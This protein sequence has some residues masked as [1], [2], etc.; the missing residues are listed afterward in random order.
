[1]SWL[2]SAI[3]AVSGLWGAHQ[4]SSAQAAA[5]RGQ[6]AWQER[7]S[8]TAHQREVADLRA[9]G[10]NPILSATG[11]NGASTPSGS[12]GAYTGQGSDL[13]A[14]INAGTAYNQ[15]RAQE[16]LMQDQ[17][18]N[19]QADTRKKVAEAKTQETVSLYIGQ[20]MLADIANTLG[21]TANLRSQV[22]Y[23]DNVLTANTQADTRLKENTIDLQNSQVLLNN[24][25]RGRIIFMTNA[26]VNK[27]YAEIRNIDA[28]TNKKLSETQLNYV[29]MVTEQVYQGNLDSQT[30]LNRLTSQGIPYDVA[31]KR[32]NSATAQADLRQR[33]DYNRYYGTT[34]TDMYGKVARLLGDVGGLAHNAK[35]IADL[36]RSVIR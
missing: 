18:L 14:G 24:A 35:P 6:M 9:A 33:Q 11:G 31:V 34:P 26:E 25:Q 2:S 5:T 7:M 1:M 30:A 12:N 10:L 8:N 29:K 27:I 4:A 16:K 23:R 13:V 3:G 22:D 19:V 20:Q 32:V 36:I 21:S 17:Q 28:D 15:Q